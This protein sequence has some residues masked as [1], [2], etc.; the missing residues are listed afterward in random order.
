MSHFFL[1]IISALVL[2]VLT[3]LSISD[4]RGKQHKHK[5]IMTAEE[6]MSL[7]SM[8]MTPYEQMMMGYKQNKSHTSGVAVAGLVLGTVGTAVAVGSC[9]FSPLFASAKSSQAKEAARAAKELAAA[10]YTATLQLMNQQNA[11]TNATIDRILGTVATE[12]AERIAG[13]QTIT[14]TVTDTVSGSQQGSLT[15][16][17]QAEL[18]AMQSVQNNL[19]NQAILG[20]L[21]ENPQKVQIYSAPQ[22]CP[23]PGCGGGY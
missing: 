3:L 16:Q 22:P 2:C 6:L 4:I 13:D 5:S 10:Q 18:S 8:G 20:N 9:V 12:R 19:L 14:Q 21:S 7:K 1:S 17:Q 23:C 11:N 15:A